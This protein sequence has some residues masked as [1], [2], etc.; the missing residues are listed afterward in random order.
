MIG[1]PEAAEEAEV[2]DD[3]FVSSPGDGHGILVGELGC[4]GLGAED[5]AS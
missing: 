5:P 4:E 1:D 2:V 3:T